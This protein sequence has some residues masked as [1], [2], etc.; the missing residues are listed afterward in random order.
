M[1]LQLWAPSKEFTIQGHYNLRW[2]GAISPPRVK[3]GGLRW[4]LEVGRNKPR[5][6]GGLWKGGKA[7][8][9]SWEVGTSSVLSGEAAHG[10]GGVGRGRAGVEEGVSSQEPEPLAAASFLSIDIVLCPFQSPFPS[11]CLSLCLSLLPQCP[12]P[13]LQ[14]SLDWWCLCFTKEGAEAPRGEWLAQHHQRRGRAAVWVGA[15]DCTLGS[16]HGSQVAQVL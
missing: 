11:A 2:A 5:R 9:K 12:T 1:C 6:R 4:G 8:T 10:V 3:V 15:S 7:G 13:S 16:Q 14:H